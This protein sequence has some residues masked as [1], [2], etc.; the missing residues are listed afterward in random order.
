M[1]NT[2]KKIIERITGRIN[3]LIIDDDP[4][5]LQMI[6]DMFSSSIFSVTAGA[7]CKQAYELIA[8]AQHPWHCWILDIAL[9]EK[10]DGLNILK[11][12]PRFPFTIMLS[13]LRSMTV[14]TEALKLGAMKVYDKDPS[15]FDALYDDVCKTAALS[16]LLHGKNTQ[17]L[18][19]FSRLFEKPLKNHDEWAESACISPRQLDRICT[20]HTSLTPRLLLP[21][22]YTIY[23]LLN[24]E[25]L[26]KVLA[27]QIN[28]NSISTELRTCFR[29]HVKFVA[30]HINKYQCYIDSSPNK[31]SL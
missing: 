17:Y 9:D 15:L 25:I 23:L 28:D 16:F 2:A 22:Y 12:Y 5:V 3:L 10:K 26:D 4:L 7:S 19:L 30:E 29:D 24:K 6:T 13:G 31:Y 21:F 1:I 11:R 14:G 27:Q 20:T 18:P 8:A